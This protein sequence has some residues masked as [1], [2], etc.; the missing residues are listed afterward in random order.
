MLGVI[1]RIAGKYGVIDTEDGVIE[2]VEQDKLDFVVNHGVEVK[3]RQPDGTY[4]QTVMAID[5]SLLNY[6]DNNANIFDC[7]SNVKITQNDEQSGTFAFKVTKNKKS[8]EYK[9]TYKISGADSVNLKFSMNITTV[10][11][12]A[13]F[14]SLRGK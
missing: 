3:G 6:G 1:Y 5:S 13:K 11:P 4:K 7:C 14:E 2:T 10:L 9:G 8:K 12:M